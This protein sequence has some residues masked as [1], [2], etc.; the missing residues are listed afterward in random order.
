MAKAMPRKICI[1]D[2]KQLSDKLGNIL[3]II[4]GYSMGIED[5]M[6]AFFTNCKNK[7]CLD[8]R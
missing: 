2:T 6:S 5:M 4:R 8:L 1:D 3:K 7:V